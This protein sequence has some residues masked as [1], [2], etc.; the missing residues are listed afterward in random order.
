M[1]MIRVLYTYYV[2]YIF[3]VKKIYS[4]RTNDQNINAYVLSFFTFFINIHTTIIIIDYSG[5]LDLGLIEFWTNNNTSERTVLGFPFVFLV[6]IFAVIIY[7][8]LIKYQPSNKIDIFRS[9]INKSTLKKF[10]SFFYIIF[11]FIF[12]LI[13]FIYILLLN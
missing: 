9:V 7:I 11:S 3:F 2:K 12:S 6:A 5:V 4:K 8:L 10:H 1:R 13:S